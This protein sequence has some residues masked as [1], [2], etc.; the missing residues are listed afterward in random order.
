MTDIEEAQECSDQH[1]NGSQKGRALSGAV[2]ARGKPSRAPLGHVSSLW[3]QSTTSSSLASLTLAFDRPL[4]VL[5]GL[6]QVTDRVDKGA[7]KFLLRGSLQSS[8]SAF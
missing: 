2:W 8:A 5:G 1:V 7:D 6:A 4:E 3:Q